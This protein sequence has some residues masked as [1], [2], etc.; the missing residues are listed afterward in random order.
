[1][2][3]TSFTWT[4]LS[5][6]ERYRAPVIGQTS[7]QSVQPSG[8]FS[9]WMRIF[10]WKNLRTRMAS[11][12]HLN[13]QILQHGHR[14]FS[15]ST[16]TLRPL[17]FLFGLVSKTFP[18]AVIHLT[19]IKPKGQALSH[20]SH[21]LGHL[22]VST[23]ISRINWGKL[24]FSTT[25]RACS[26]LMVTFIAPKGQSISHIPQKLHFYKSMSTLAFLTFSPW[27][28]GCF[29]ILIASFGQAKAQIWQP[30]HKSLLR[31]NL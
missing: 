19:L 20:S 21:L 5:T 14:S 2:Q 29:S 8:H 15:M 16:F 9:W 27:I 1:M 25:E 28:L 24:S 26:P 22:L 7:K 12:G 18:S 6:S 10:P 13:S 11:L 31:F 17:L 4:F 23:W 3:K 30:T